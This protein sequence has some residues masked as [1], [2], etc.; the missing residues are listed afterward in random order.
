MDIA[1]N[2]SIYVS[3]PEFAGWLYK[4]GFRWRKLWRKRW[5]ALHGAEIVYM[6]KE[7]TL[8]N[9]AT[10]KFSKAQII[11]STVIVNSDIDGDENGFAIQINDGNQPTWYLRAESLREKKSWL[12]R[13]SHAQAIVQ[14]VSFYSI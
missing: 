14:W 13:L 11:S 10:L 7:P 3:S 5:V 4:K 8:E 2:S 1:L 12:I 9:S 6:E